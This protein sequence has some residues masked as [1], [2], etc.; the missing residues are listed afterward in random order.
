MLTAR[1]WES[2]RRCSAEEPAALANTAAAERRGPR[3]RRRLVPLAAVLTNDTDLVEPIRIGTQEAGLPVILHTPIT[4]PA[5]SLIDA[6]I[7]VRHSQPY[8]GPCQLP[9]PVP[10]LGKN[11]IGKPVEWA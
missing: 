5:T 1:A 8:I 3:G 4:K 7:D 9:D 2:K 6:A 11:P 10:V